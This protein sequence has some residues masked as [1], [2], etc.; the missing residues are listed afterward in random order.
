MSDRGETAL[1]EGEFSLDELLMPTYA[2][3]PVRFVSGSGTTLV[4]EAGRSYL[5]FLS[6]IAVTS[7]GHCHP[8]VTDAVVSQARR[9]WH[10]SNLFKNDLAPRV[11]ERLDRLA[12]GGGQVF[13]SNSGAEAVEAAIKLARRYS[14]PQSPVIISA[15]NSFHGRTMGALA[16]T[17]QPAKSEPFHPLP[18]GFRHVSYADIEALEAAMDQ[19]VAAVL[20]EPIQGEGGVIVPPVGYL[21]ALRKLCDDRGVLLIMDE[22]QT[23]LGRT[24]MW[25]ATQREGV[26]PDI[27]TVAK[28]LGNGMPI[29]ACWARREVASSFRP[30]D[31]GTT[32]GGQPLAASAALATL[33]VM[34]REDVPGRAAAGGGRLGGALERVAGVESVR[35][36]GL[37]L[38]AVLH[39]GVGSAP[40]IARAC[41]DAG[42]VINAPGERILRFAPPL[43]VDDDEIDDAVEILTG[44]VEDAARRGGDRGPS[45]RGVADTEGKG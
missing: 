13:F 3:A 25:F 28:A 36:A 4:D 43:L 39:Q 34:E 12:G 2:P 11:A 24:G 18:G 30:G 10:V 19:S 41:L 40:E 6:G 37:L 33:E 14:G 22:I 5:D 35:G 45:A 29:G 44:V 7:L 8:E 9:L 17:G 21:S 42:L 27:M 31:H 23:G 15:L 26:V 20:M 32:Y 38:A 16:A 1:G